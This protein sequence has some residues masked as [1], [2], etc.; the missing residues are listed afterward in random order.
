MKFSLT[1]I[2]LLIINNFISIIAQSTNKRRDIRAEINE[3]SIAREESD[4]KFAEDIASIQN[5]QKKESKKLEEE[6]KTRIKEQIIK[7]GKY[8]QSLEKNV[9][10]PHMVYRQIKGTDNKYEWILSTEIDALDSA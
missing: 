3:I 7:N 1:F 4:K 5:N 2:Q 9:D 6:I 10:R 8:M